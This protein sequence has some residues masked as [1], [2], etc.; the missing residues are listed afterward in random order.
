MT[1]LRD[2][3]RSRHR[4]QSGFTLV[5]VL[6]TTAIGAIIMVPLLAWMTLAFQT[7]VS[8]TNNSARTAARNLVA[9]YLP[10]DVV[11]AKTIDLVP[12][13]CVTTPPVS[14]P[15]G[16]QRV[17]LSMVAAG[18]TPA[19]TVYLVR[20]VDS[21]SAVLVRRTCVGPVVDDTEIVEH[22]AL[23]ISTSVTASCQPCNQ[24]LGR[25]DLSIALA[26]GQG[27]IKVTASQRIGS[28]S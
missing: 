17:V 6:I 24:R 12:A 22:V 3:L 26:E 21:T 13:D 15:S 28:D 7:Q 8:L 18:A 9:S 23:P 14:G 10:R 2:H 20:Q 1:G 11:G 25:V 5:E 16:V 19:R 27:S 4:G